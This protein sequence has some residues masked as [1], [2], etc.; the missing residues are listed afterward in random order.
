MSVI[1]TVGEDPIYLLKQEICEKKSQIEHEKR[2]IS[3]LKTVLAS[4]RLINESALSHTMSPFNVTSIKIETVERD[5]SS[6]LWLAFR[7]FLLVS[8]ILLAC[9]IIL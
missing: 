4:K 1:C 9:L 7:A 5:G 3:N 2:E 6:I 8:S